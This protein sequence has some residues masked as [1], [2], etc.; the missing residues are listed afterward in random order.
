VDSKLSPFSFGDSNFL[1]K[2]ESLWEELSGFYGRQCR[3][4]IQFMLY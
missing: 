3:G 2:L 4:S 1:P